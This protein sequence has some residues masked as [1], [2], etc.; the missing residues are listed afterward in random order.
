MNFGKASKES[1]MNDYYIP[2][3]RIKGISKS[4]SI[5]E[6]IFVDSITHPTH[7]ES[8]GRDE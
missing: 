4:V 1:L 2:D 7:S 8:I 6:T 5:I 3:D